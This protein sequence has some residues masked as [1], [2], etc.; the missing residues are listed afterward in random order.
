M[1]RCSPH[2][3]FAAEFSTSPPPVVWLESPRPFTFYADPFGIWRDG[4][5]HLCVEAYDYRSKH[6]VSEV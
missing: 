5:L 3:L 4:K 6:G 2:A 1:V